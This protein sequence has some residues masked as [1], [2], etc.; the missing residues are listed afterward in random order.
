MSRA[1]ACWSGPVISARLRLGRQLHEGI[2]GGSRCAAALELV[3]RGK[4]GRDQNQGRGLWSRLHLHL[5]VLVLA[6]DEGAA[7][8]NDSIPL[9]SPRHVAR[10]YGAQGVGQSSGDAIIE[11]VECG[12]IETGF[13]V[14]GARR[15]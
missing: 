5:K 12:G 6:D 8:G 7:V 1:W 3:A 14:V 10:A 11:F 4:Y 13:T 2:G 9:E 15:D